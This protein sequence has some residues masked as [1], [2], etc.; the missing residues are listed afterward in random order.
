MP[1]NLIF[2]IKMGIEIHTKERKGTHLITIQE[3]YPKLN[4]CQ[5]SLLKEAKPDHLI[6]FQ[7]PMWN[8]YKYMICDGS[9]LT[10]NEGIAVN[11]ALSSSSLI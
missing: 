6:L 10:F 3:I 2:K 11:M 5:I 4:P 9:W 8:G 1:S 7:F